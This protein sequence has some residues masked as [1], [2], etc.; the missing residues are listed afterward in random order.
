MILVKIFLFAFAIVMTAGTGFQL[1]QAGFAQGH[2]ENPFEFERDTLRPATIC[3]IV[4]LVCFVLA[5][6]I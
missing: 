1:W 3:G 6:Q 4:A 5:S 2:K